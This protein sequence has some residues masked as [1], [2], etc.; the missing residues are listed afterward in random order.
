M[1]Q[2]AEETWPVRLVSPSCSSP[3]LHTRGW[4]QE[5]LSLSGPV[6]S[7]PGNASQLFPKGTCGFS[8]LVGWLGES[9]VYLGEGA[10]TGIYYYR[11]CTKEKVW[12][13]RCSYWRMG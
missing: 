1:R 9:R 2:A 12:E 3:A 5:A 11:R 10:W 7:I 6:W 4:I 8:Y 13:C